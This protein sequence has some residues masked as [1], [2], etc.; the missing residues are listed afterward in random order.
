MPI[1][2][3]EVNDMYGRFWRELCPSLRKK[4]HEK[5]EVAVP[6]AK[7][8]QTEFLAEYRKHKET[9]DFD[10]RKTAYWE[11]MLEFKKHDIH[12]GNYYDEKGF[13]ERIGEFIGLYHR[14]KNLG[15]Y[16]DN[17]YQS[18]IIGFK[19]KRDRFIITDGH[20]RASIIYILNQAKVPV[21]ESKEHILKQ[22]NNLI[23][24][25]N[26]KKEVY[27]PLPKDLDQ[28]YKV[29]RPCFNRYK[30]IE[31]ALDGNNTVLDV[32]CNL[33]YFVRKLNNSKKNF[34]AD[35]I[36]VDPKYISLCKMLEYF[37]PTNAKY[38]HA[39]FRTFEGRRYD[40][41]L[42][43][44]VFHHV[45]REC[46]PD[47]QDVFN[48]ACTK[49]M[50]RAKRGI[51]IEAPKNEIKSILDPFLLRNWKEKKIYEDAERDSIG[52]LLTP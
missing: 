39:D 18:L 32:G 47:K 23:I 34:M 26:G 17:R 40:Y 49:A 11:M 35:G 6:V 14:L 20:H 43:L 30:E 44:S 8:P 1:K 3:V 5:G 15:Y 45:L 9:L 7:L 48:D 29:L 12:Y 33:G 31:K 37:E 21:L 19:D 2:I 13:L 25:L 38:E 36:D 52:Y 24:E 42:F 10:F 50:Q 16:F 4:D 22:V 27:Q 28:G 51:V 46:L 41:V